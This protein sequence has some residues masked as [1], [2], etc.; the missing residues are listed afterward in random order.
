MKKLFIAACMVLAATTANAQS[1]FAGTGS[2]TGNTGSNCTGVGASSLNH[3]NSGYGN[4]GFGTSSLSNA[5]TGSRNTGIGTSALSNNTLAS[6]NTGIG[7]IALASNLTGLENTAVGAEALP[8]NTTGNYNTAVGRGAMYFNT[9]GSNSSAFGYQS[10]QSTLTAWNNNAFG[11]KSLTNT[12]GGSENCGFGNVVLYANDS[13]SF[14]CS[15]GNYTL[16]SN[17]KGNNNCAFGTYAMDVNTTGHDNS[18]F[19][20]N[21]LTGNTTGYSNA[22]LGDY[23]MDHN[24]TGYNNTGVGSNAMHLA[25][26]A[27][28]T[29]AVGA[30][31]GAARNKYVKCTFIGGTADASVNNLTN[32]TAIGYGAK[33]SASYKVQV[34]NTAVTSIGGQVSWTTA[35]DIRLKTNIKD[36]KLGLDFINLLHPVTYN[37][38]AEGQ[39][40]ITYTGLLAQE[41]DAAAKKE[42]TEFSG[43]D[44]NGEYWG[45]RYGD[46]AVPLISAVQE[47]SKQNNDLKKENE[48]MKSA[49]LEI[50]QQ[51]N[52]LANNQKISSTQVAITQLL[53]SP[54]PANDVVKIAVSTSGKSIS[55]QVRVI[56]VNGNVVKTY[57]TNESATF[58]MNTSSIANGTYVV[59][60]AN[61]NEIVKTEKL[62]IQHP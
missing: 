6:Y 25:T 18:A 39:E 28:N 46:L 53:V 61:G 27:D 41:V 57:S 17:T 2:G 52:A 7:Y 12:R 33:V 14:N 13:G 45:I 48:L 50:Q 56:A 8:S 32:A 11:W 10:L 29:V 20:F 30:S 42:H 59:E 43:V 44:K 24:T 60:L 36:S 37:Y 35:S 23:A 58:E 54:N 4:C 62:V 34:G 1:Y 31:A 9:T 21:A 16:A 40:T 38:K 19:G 3:N 47:L 15:F 22:V 49:L 55:L 51:M 5:T 26:I